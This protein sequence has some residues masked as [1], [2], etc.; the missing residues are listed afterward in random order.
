MYR[1]PPDLVVEILSPS[2]AYYDLK[3]KKRGYQS[4]GVKEYWVVDPEDKS[5]EE[6]GL[7]EDSFDL[8]DQAAGEGE[9]GSEILAGLRVDV[10]A[11]FRPIL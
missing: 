8:L 3:Q 10:V 1:A 11:I 4:A 5:M 2:T 6:Y 7:D 9:T